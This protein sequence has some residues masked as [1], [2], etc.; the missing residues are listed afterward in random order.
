MYDTAQNF[1]SF[2][3]VFFVCFV[4]YACRLRLCGE[5]IFKGNLK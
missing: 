4:V 5:I 1:R 2:S 3:L